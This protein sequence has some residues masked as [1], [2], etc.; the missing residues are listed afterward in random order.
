MSNNV[1]LGIETTCDETA[2]A[3]FKNN[4][5]ASNIVY[6]Q[7]KHHQP[8]KGVIPELAARLHYQKLDLVIHEALASS[9]TSLADITH[10]AYCKEPGFYPALHIGK[11]AAQTLGMYLNIPVTGFNHLQAHIYACNIEKP[12]TFPLIAC[13]FS[14]GHTNVFYFKKEF[15]P[16]LILSSHDDAIGECIDKVAVKMG[17][18]YPG[19]PMIEALAKKGKNN[20]YFPQLNLKNEYFSFSGVKSYVINLLKKQPDINHND[21]ACSFQEIIFNYC[22]NMLKK[23]IK[24]YYIKSFV[25]SGGVAANQ[26]LRDKIDQLVNQ[27]HLK[28]YFAPLNLCCDNAG[29][30]VNLANKSLVK[31]SK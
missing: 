21:L 24:K 18:D 19:G 8:N 28:S 17:Y 5:I 29:M 10:I 1:I 11:I 12:F 26:V 25:L 9:K 20:I 16:Q 7:I 2:A 13:V 6:S 14:G 3:I 27:H 31:N 30:L 4:K 15:A 23:T 22:I